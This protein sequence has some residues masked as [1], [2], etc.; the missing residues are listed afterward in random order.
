MPGLALTFT[1]LSGSSAS[2]CTAPSDD[3]DLAQLVLEEDLAESERKQDVDAV[4]P[5]V[6]G[7][8]LAFLGCTGRGA[9]RCSFSANAAVLELDS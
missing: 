5:D 6:L 7:Y 1:L 3:E 9:L 8:R 2:T 4:D